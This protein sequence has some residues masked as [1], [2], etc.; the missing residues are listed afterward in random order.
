MA[1]PAYGAFP[2]GYAHCKVITTQH[3]MVS[4]ANDLT[5]Y[6]LTVILT[7]A[8]LKTTANGGYV[9]SNSGYDI[10]FYPDCSGTGA[11]LKWEMESYAPATGAIV[12]HVLRPTLSHTID[13]TIGLF[14]G[15]AFSSFQSTAPAV[16][17]SSYKGVYHLADGTT[18]N[19]SDSTSNA[20]NLG[21]TGAVVATAGK[22]DG[23]ASFTPSNRLTRLSP[24]FPTGTQS[25]TLEGWFKMGANQTEELMGWGD[26]SGGTTRFSV[27][28][29]NDGKLYL[30][31]SGHDAHFSWSYDTNWHHIAFTLPAGQTTTSGVLG[32][33]DGVAQTMTGDGGT[34]ATTATEFRLSGL[35]TYTTSGFWYT[36][37]LDEIRISNVARTADW[38]L[39]EYRNQSAPGTYISAGP[40]MDS[41][42]RIR[43]SV[44]SN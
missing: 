8:D 2:N 42:T 4:G 13:D 21:N 29:Q 7:D 3:S 31:C 28:W 40:R 25:R 27:Y 6:P 38:I 39:T 19:M 34:L 30:E 41:S 5:N 36:G 23:G 26:N 20:N 37:L 18:L 1:L 22:V 17:D 9:N 16:W 24:N 35:A 12:A 14:Y 33:L 10:A 11:A 44:K 15:G 32:Y 43:H